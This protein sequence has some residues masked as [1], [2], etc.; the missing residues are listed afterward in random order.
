MQAITFT[1]YGYIKYTLNLLKSVEVNNVN[2][3]IK[4]SVQI[5]KVTIF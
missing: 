1:N 5:K 4:S 2:L 3:Q